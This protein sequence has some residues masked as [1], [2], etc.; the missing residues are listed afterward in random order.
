MI[1]WSDDG[2][3]PIPHPPEMSPKN[4]SEMR[5]MTTSATRMRS[6]ERTTAC[7]AACPT[8]RVAPASAH[9][10]CYAIVTSGHMHF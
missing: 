4:I 5:T 2:D 9:S 1:R 3:D 8:S 6:E 10:A 7:I